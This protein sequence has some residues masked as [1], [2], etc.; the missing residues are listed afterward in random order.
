MTTETI[1]APETAVRRKFWQRWFV[2]PV[3]KQL[4]QGVT[5]E[6]ISLSLSVGTA[7]A[8][9]PILGTTT[10]L[11]V[12][13]GVLLRLNQPFLQGLNALCTFIY[14]PLMLLFV[15]LG[16]KVAGSPPSSFNVV[17]MISL[18]SYHPREFL[19]VFGVTALHAAL[20]WAI[21]APLWLPLVYFVALPPLRAAALRL[22]RR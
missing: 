18:A 9:F 6:K 13:A 22:S 2:D 14:F 5:P 11:C 16:D 12:V 15:R 17:S 8:L 4:T 1:N 21:V 20:G 3:V 19:K 7:L 10:T